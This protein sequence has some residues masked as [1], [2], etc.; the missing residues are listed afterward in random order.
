LNSE[1]PYLLGA[2]VGTSSCKTVLADVEGHT[3]AS[4]QR[5]YPTTRPRPGWA[6]QDP[7]DWYRAFC[8][9]V[10]Q[11]L[12]DASI[13]PEEIAAISITGPAHNA[14]L[15]DQEDHV[16]RPVIHWSDRRSKEQCQWLQER[17]ENVIF[18]VT[19]QPVNPSW[20]FAQLL[21]VK[22]NEPEIW[23]KIH[24]ILVQKDYVVYRLTG[25]F[26]T[27][28]YDATGTQ[29]FNPQIG[30]W[31]EDLCA[32]LELPLAFLPNQRM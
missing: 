3:I 12:D 16:I 11:I 8:Q 4:T 23:Q 20:T 28:E 9:S 24:R 13:L 30:E 7:E 1:G 29:L 5:G 17:H 22:N 6:E 14:V 19:F 26:K 32:L 25:S 27:D 15:L 31:S 2:D 10:R 21:W 18:E